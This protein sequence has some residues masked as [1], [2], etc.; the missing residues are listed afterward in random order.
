MK[1]TVITALGSVLAMSANAAEL[2]RYD[3]EAHCNQVASMGGTSSSTLLNGCMDM[4][5]KAYDA[6]KGTW[7]QIPD[8]A[9]QHCE[10]VA[11][12]GGDGS[13]NLLK[14]CIDMEMKAGAQPRK[15][16]Y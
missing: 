12:F 13:Y 14:G 16:Q 4:E 9:R 10:Q 6:L 8:K 1:R 3:V 15:F 11:S 2:P 7:E 5:Q